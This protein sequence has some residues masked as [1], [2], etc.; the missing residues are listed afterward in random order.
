M[1]IFHFLWEIAD[2]TKKRRAFMKKHELKA[3]QKPVKRSQTCKDSK[4]G[5]GEVIFGSKKKRDKTTSIWLVLLAFCH[6]FGTKRNQN[7]KI[8]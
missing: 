3:V 5:N 4:C 1:G 6:D 7:T 2:F 8:F